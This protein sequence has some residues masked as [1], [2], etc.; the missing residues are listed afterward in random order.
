MN[1]IYYSS[2]LRWERIHVT[3]SSHI[4]MEHLSHLAYVY[5]CLSKKKNLSMNGFMRCNTL[6]SF[7]WKTGQ[8]YGAGKVE[9]LEGT[10]IILFDPFSVIIFI[11]LNI[12]TI[13]VVCVCTICVCEH[14][15]VRVCF[16]SEG[17][18]PDCIS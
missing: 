16:I 11:L 12:F 2:E 5:V 14:V 13:F 6:D 7:C 18:T 3:H 9:Y 15:R 10:I 4:L 17:L 1:D 8:T